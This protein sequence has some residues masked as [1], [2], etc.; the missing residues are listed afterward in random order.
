MKLIAVFVESIVGEWRAAF[1]DLPGCKARGFNLVTTIQ[2]AMCFCLAAFP[3][4]ASRITVESSFNRI[5]IVDPS[6]ALSDYLAGRGFAIERFE[7]LEAFHLG[8]MVAVPPDWLQTDAAMRDL[9]VRF[10]NAIVAR[11]TWFQMAANWRAG[12]SKASDSQRILAAIDWQS[13]DS[14]SA[15]GMRVGMIDSSL[16]PDHPALQGTAIVRRQFTSG[17]APTTDTTHGTAIAAMLVGRS[18][19]R[20][21]CG[22]LRGATLFHA[23][24]FRDTAHGPMASSGDF[25]RS[26]NWLIQSGV[27]VINASVTSSSENPVVLYAMSLL[28]QEKV[29]LVAAAGNDG[30]EGPPAYP[31]AIPSAFAVTAVSTTG[32]AYHYANVGD[33]I[34]IAAPGI[35]VPTTSRGIRS[36]TSLAV[37]FVTAAVARMIQRCGVSPLEA[38]IILQGN[39]RDLGPRGRDARFGWGLLQMQPSCD[40]SG[41]M[42]ADR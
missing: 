8:L 27:K 2:L 17:H 34:D 1:P 21:V 26:V 35:D 10:P 39:A 23:S 14:A 18:D 13:P 25:L 7:Q 28:R 20:S 15:A 30:P 6:P 11:E 41:R 42:I 5:L 36:G 24:I 19:D 31:A 22:L 32:D 37:P 9:R 40:Q 12:R 33:Y 38:E 16:D 3:V 4:A 29:I